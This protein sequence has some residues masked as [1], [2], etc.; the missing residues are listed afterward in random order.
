[1]EF[2]S[3]QPYHDNVHRNLTETIFLGTPNEFPL[4]PDPT[5]PAKKKEPRKH[6]NTEEEKEL[7]ELFKEIPQTKVQELIVFVGPIGAGK[8]TFYR[9]YFAKYPNYK[10]IN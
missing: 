4:I 5:V 1:M 2:Y 10:R 7:I 3:G 8:S 6:L 9:N